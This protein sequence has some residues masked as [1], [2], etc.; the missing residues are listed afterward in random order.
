MGWRMSDR[1]KNLVEQLLHVDLDD[2]PLRPRHK[3]SKHRGLWL[4]FLAVCIAF[5]AVA[6]Y[7]D[8]RQ[9]LRQNNDTLATGSA[10]VVRA[11]STTLNKAQLSAISQS[12]KQ[13]VDSYDEQVNRLLGQPAERSSAAEPKQ[14]V[15]NDANYVPVT[16]VNTLSMA[17]PP[18]PT[19]PRLN[20]AS[21][22]G[23]V[24]VVEETKPSCWPFK[25]G[26]I[27]CRK[28]KK[29]AK[30]GLNQRCYNSAHSN[31][32][33]CRRAALYNSVQ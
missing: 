31:T 7:L 27:N 29:A 18:Q 8:S 30:S 24:T 1:K 33:E 10:V 3:R 12:T 22:Q 14:T 6:N 5:G 13:H 20:A 15:F 21:R 11:S 16:Q 9:L 17:I 32:E 19:A 26:S 25:P 4:S 23:Y 28:Y 2:A